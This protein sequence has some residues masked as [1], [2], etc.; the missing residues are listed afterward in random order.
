MSGPRIQSAAIGLTLLAASIGH[1]GHAEIVV[2]G[3]LVETK[4]AG[5]CSGFLTLGTSQR[6]V[7]CLNGTVWDAATGLLWLKQGQCNALGVQGDGTGTWAEAM[8]AAAATADGLDCDGDGTPELTDGSQPGDWRLPTRWEWSQTTLRAKNL[9]CVDGGL[10][11]GPSLTNDAGDD[12]WGRGL[13]PSSLASVFQSRPYW[14]STSPASAPG[15]ASGWSLFDA[16]QSSLPR[17][18]VPPRPFI[19]P[20]RDELAADGNPLVLVGDA[21]VETDAGGPCYGTVGLGLERYVDCGDG[22]VLDALTGLLWLRDATCSSLP[23]GGT[24]DY[25][26]V[27]DAVAELGDGT[28]GLTDGSEPGDW[29]LATE[30][31]WRQTTDRAK[32]LGCTNDGAGDPPAL[33]DT[34]GTGCLAAGSTPFVGLPTTFNRLYWTSQ[35]FDFTP[36][37]VVAYSLKNANTQA[38]QKSDTTL[39]AWPVRPRGSR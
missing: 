9:G 27:V 28:C 35:I 1:A 13:G 4:A 39:W 34:A 20:V 11:G 16:T 5:V 38:H 32:A 2:D 7:D 33:T 8:E 19:W 10:K 14:S 21:P 23:G 25:L 24:G 15:L 36:S 6:Y 22:T 18:I 37:T 30:D 31:E 17:S 29:R 26:D 3:R 12:C